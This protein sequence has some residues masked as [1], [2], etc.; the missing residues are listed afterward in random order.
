[1]VTGFGDSS[2]GDT[3]Q[4]CPNR[5]SRL[6]HQEIALIGSREVFQ[7]RDHTRPS[8]RAPRTARRSDQHAL[9]SLS[10]TPRPNSASRWADDSVFI[11]GSFAQTGSAF[12]GTNGG[13]ARRLLFEAPGVVAGLGDVVVM[14][15][16]V[17]QCGRHLG[18]AEHAG[19]LAEGEVRGD[20]NGGALV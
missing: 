5:R 8:L 10:P 7:T 17:E 13:G 18:V 14:C 1:M 20:D 3:E 9:S 4:R 16:V 19:P 6:R 15:Q 11:N 2:G 12:G